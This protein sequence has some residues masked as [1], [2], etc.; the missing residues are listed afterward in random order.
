MKTVIVLGVEYSIFYLTVND[1]ERLK[2][3]YGFTDWTTKS[4]IIDKEMND[5]NLRTVEALRMKVLRHEIIHAFLLE[6]GLHECTA[7]C[8]AWADSEEMVDWFA[9]QGQ[10]I[11]EA[12]RLSGAL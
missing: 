12:W 2:D 6:S 7:S 9:N 8:E 4:I 10:K 11:Y 1:D 5:C 3:S